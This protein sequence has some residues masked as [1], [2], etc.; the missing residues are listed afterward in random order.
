MKSTA[1]IFSSS[2]HGSS[3]GREGLDVALSFSLVTKKISFFF[4]DDG[5][6]QLMLY[7]NPNLIHSHHHSLSFKI[8]LLYEIKGFFF[9]NDQLISVD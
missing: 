8:F 3:I 5:V 4:I 1:F 9:V 7:Q 6:L 2:P